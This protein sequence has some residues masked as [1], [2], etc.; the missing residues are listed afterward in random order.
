MYYK[1]H[2]L[3]LSVCT[4]FQ[5]WPPKPN[6]KCR[7]SEEILHQRSKCKNKKKEGTRDNH[8]SA[9]IIALLFWPPSLLHFI[10]YFIYTFIGLLI[11]CIA[12]V[13]ITLKLSLRLPA[14]PKALCLVTWH[15]LIKTICYRKQR[16]SYLQR[17]RN[18][19]FGML[20]YYRWGP[21]LK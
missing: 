15:D 5:D 17:E 4:P 12:L 20:S 18:S 6:R 10:S 14:M 9:W 11:C 3:L 19:G 2:C 16:H 8:V 21:T 13:L 1:S 7:T